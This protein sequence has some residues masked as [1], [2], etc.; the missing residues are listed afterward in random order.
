MMRVSVRGMVYDSA[1]ECADA[2]GVSV[3]TVYCAVSRRTTDTLGMG[4]GNRTAKRGGRKPQPVTIGGISFESMA[5]ASRALGF[6][7]RYV[8][9][10]MANGGATARANLLRACMQYRAKRDMAAIREAQ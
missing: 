7:R 5:S 10:V 4:R 1:R 3:A 9:S 8:A 6:G 2:L